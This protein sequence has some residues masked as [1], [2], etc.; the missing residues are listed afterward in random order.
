MQAVIDPVDQGALEHVKDFHVDYKEDP[1]EYDLTFVSC[2][3]HSDFP[4]L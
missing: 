4:V 1:R 2:P 3:L